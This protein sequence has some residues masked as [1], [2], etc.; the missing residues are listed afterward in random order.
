MVKYWTR[1]ARSGRPRVIRTPHRPKQ[2]DDSPLSLQ[3]PTPQ[4]KTRSNCNFDHQCSTF[5]N[6][7]LGN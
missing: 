1:F 3:A 7:L 5:W 2:S 6:D 4:P